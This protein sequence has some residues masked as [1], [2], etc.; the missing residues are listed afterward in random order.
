MNYTGTRQGKVT[1]FD[2]IGTRHRHALYRCV[3]DC[4]GEVL[5]D[6]GQLL[7]NENISCKSCYKGSRYED[8]TGRQ[9][10]R[11][12]IIREDVNHA[13]KEG[14]WICRCDC[15]V[16]VTIT[17]GR[18]NYGKTI[19]CGC[20]NKERIVKRKI[21]L[22]GNRY[23]RLLVLR[24]ADGNDK[25]KWVC[26]CDCGAEVTTRSTSLYSGAT[27]SC[28]CI[29]IE[30]LSGSNSIFWEGG[31]TYSATRELRRKSDQSTWSKYIRKRDGACCNCG[32]VDNLHAHHIE[33]FNDHPEKRLDKDNG[34][35]L[36]VDCHKLFHR[37]YGKKRND[38]QQ[39]YEFLKE[40][41]RNEF[42]RDRVLYS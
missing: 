1:V 3:C 17:T 42:R 31:T 41:E 16:E 20:Y 9:F 7:R 38:K 32:C 34:L 36:C 29:R 5:L 24:P 40:N 18:L 13:S 6:S 14:H 15:G 23:G 33:N 2:K 4:G 37:V 35:A 11:L 12:T 39:I 8:L 30:N 19:S 27:K 25:S 10:N 28:G 26:V 21:D 22:T